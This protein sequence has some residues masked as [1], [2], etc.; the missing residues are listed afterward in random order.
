MNLIKD[1]LSSCL[2]I[3]TKI[4]NY[5]K[6]VI[7]FFFLKKKRVKP[8][9][10]KDTYLTPGWEV[11]PTDRPSPGYSNGPKCNSPY[12]C[13]WP[14]K[15][16]LVSHGRWIELEMWWH[17]KPF[18]LSLDHRL[19][20]VLKFWWIYMNRNHIYLYIVRFLRKA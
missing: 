4:D 2:I 1:Y 6:N 12:P 3:L 10:I 17:P 20:V 7:F 5:K 14:G 8:G 11:Q 9:S 13:R 16:D 18:P 19:P 15:Y